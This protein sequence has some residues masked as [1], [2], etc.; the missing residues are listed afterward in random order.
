MRVKFKYDFNH[1]FLAGRGVLVRVEN[2]GSE[3]NLSATRKS[4]AE[5]TTAGLRF[6]QVSDLCLFIY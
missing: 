3:E 6:S 1:K 2:F 5:S 4:R